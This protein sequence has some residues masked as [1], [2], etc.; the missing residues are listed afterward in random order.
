MLV[1]RAADHERVGLYL[2]VRM[3][4]SHVCCRR[5]TM[6]EL[7]C[8]SVSVSDFPSE[9]SENYSFLIEEL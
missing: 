4:R 2:A 6:L 9:E 1:V 3:V 5:L 7:L 8:F